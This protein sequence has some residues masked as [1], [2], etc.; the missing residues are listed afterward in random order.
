MPGE[1]LQECASFISSGASELILLGQNVNA[2]GK[3]LAWQ[4]FVTLLRQIA[5]LPGLERL[6][7]VTPH[8]ADMDGDIVGL[9]GELE[10]LCPRLHLP[11]QSG[12]DKILKSMRRRYDR[13]VF[14]DLARRLRLARP[15]LALST[16]LIVGFPG[17]TEED[18][19]ATLEMMRECGFMSS[20]SFCYSDRPGTRASLMPGK[21]EPETMLK[22]LGR[23]QSLQAE[24]SDAWLAARVGQKARV[25]MET[26]APRQKDGKT[27][28]GK[29]EYGVTV[30]LE[31]ENARPGM[32]CDVIISAAKKHTLAGKLIAGQTGERN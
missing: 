28:Q 21:I 22:R 31:N 9:F 3:D 25:L 5:S 7:F 15:D 29:D 4:D 23:L 8:P 17:E 26:P 10:N 11:L 20:Y 19:E 13:K 14:L 6:R 1:I 18:F 32:Y 30:T 16:D 27:W 12:S 2:Y 24:L